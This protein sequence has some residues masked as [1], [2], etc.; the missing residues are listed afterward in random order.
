MASRVTGQASAR[1]LSAR[2]DVAP[3]VLDANTK[4]ALQRSAPKIVRKVDASVGKRLPHRG[5]Y[6]ETMLKSL[7]Y[8][9]R[10]KGKGMTLSVWADG[11][12]SRRDLPA[13]N[14]GVIR[15][16][17]FGRRKDKWEVTRIRPGA[18][19]DPLRHEAPRIIVREIAK[20]LQD[21]GHFVEGK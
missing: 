2:L 6:A 1:A 16:P 4:K 14:R 15:H 3:K 9:A 7:R 10:I 19:T 5:G 13:V 17:V 8:E 21:T 11:K 18:V 20:G 12:I